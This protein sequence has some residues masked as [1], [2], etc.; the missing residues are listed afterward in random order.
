M[1]NGI[2]IC[3]NLWFVARD[4]ARGDSAIFL[5]FFSF[6]ITREAADVHLLEVLGLQDDGGQLARVWHVAEGEADVAE[7]ERQGLFRDRRC[8]FQIKPIRF[9]SRRFPECVENL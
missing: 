3:P 4:Y 5:L 6:V 7:L 2:L 8:G 9:S 1:P